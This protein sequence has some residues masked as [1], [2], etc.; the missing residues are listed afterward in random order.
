MDDEEPEKE[1]TKGEKWME[2]LRRVGGGR[3][4]GDKGIKKQEERGCSK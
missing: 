4:V 3:E 1:L 2:G